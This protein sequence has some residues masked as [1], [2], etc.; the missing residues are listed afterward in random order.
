VHI[1]LLFRVVDLE[2]AQVQHTAF[3]EENVQHGHWK[4]GESWLGLCVVL[5]E[6]ET[7]GPPTNLL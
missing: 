4:K 2:L 1:I 7:Q 5:N 3:G 6:T